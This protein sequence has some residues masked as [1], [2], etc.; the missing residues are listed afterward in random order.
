MRLTDL[1]PPDQVQRGAAAYLSFALDRWSK[2]LVGADPEV[3]RIFKYLYGGSQSSEDGRRRRT[4]QIARGLLNHYSAEGEFWGLVHSGDRVSQVDVPAE[5]IAE[6]P[7]RIVVPT[8][9]QHLAAA[10]RPGSAREI[11]T[12]DLAMSSVGCG[13]AYALN[14]EAALFRMHREP[15]MTL[16]FFLCS[17]LTTVPVAVDESRLRPL[18]PDDGFPSVGERAAGPTQLLLALLERARR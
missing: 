8:L 3:E 11:L 10:R 17:P 13:I 7:Q 9:D 14:Q 2:G 15:W 1:G 6:H 12:R 5:S 4:V 18:N 16:R